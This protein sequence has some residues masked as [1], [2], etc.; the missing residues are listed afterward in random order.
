M[1][2]LLSLLTAVATSAVDIIG[3]RLVGKVSPYVIGWAGGFF[4]L[5][6]LL[7]LLL[8]ERP[9]PVAPIFWVALGTAAVTL[10]TSTIL[11]YKAIERGDLSETVPIL[12][13]TPIFLLITS[14]LIVGEFPSLLGILGILLIVGGAQILFA[15]PDEP[16]LLGPFR[17][18]IRAPGS[19]AMLWVAIIYSVGANIDKVGVQASSPAVWGLAINM[20]MALLL[21]AMMVM[22]G[23]GVVGQILQHKG[24]LILTGV[25]VALI[26]LFQMSALQLTIVPYVIS[27]KRIS[28]VLTSA[29]GVLFLREQGGWRR[30]FAAGLMVAGVFVVSF[31]R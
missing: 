30:I 25:C 8:L 14:P 6:F 3:K 11:F 2:L 29:W 20:V 10:S 21:G 4:S 12:T 1:W 18:M 22:K 28:I 7:V 23:R 27:V 13:F 5:P 26:F 17:R 31:A 15:H 16:G 9:G 24:P 19:R